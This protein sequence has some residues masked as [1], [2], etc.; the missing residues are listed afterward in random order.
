MKYLIP[1]ILLLTSLNVYAADSA[2]LVI[3]EDFNS[4]TLSYSELNNDTSV[5][6]LLRSEAKIDTAYGGGFVSKIN[7]TPSSKTKG[8]DWFY[9]V[10]GILA[11]EG[12][13]TYKVNP[14][15]H[16]WWDYHT[17]KTGELVSAVIGAFPD[18]FLNGY[19]NNV[20]PTAI[21]SSKPQHSSA[22]LLEKF[23]SNS[24]VQNI[25]QRDLNT[26]DT[27]RE[28]Y[29]IIIGAWSEISKNPF[30]IDLYKASKKVGF[31]VS[32]SDN[33]LTYNDKK[34]NSAST[35]MAL[36]SAFS[37]TPTWLITGTGDELVKR[38]VD[39]L[40]NEPN[41]IENIAAALITPETIYSLPGMHA[42]N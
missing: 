10:N 33:L 3:S 34:F 5:M 9:Y 1:I 40:I 2:K 29:K 26:I 8:K 32:F 21:Y 13:L 25:T 28:E 23:L 17:W 14:G 39:V 4:P 12:A 27:K 36:N 41:K 22:D 7:D 31:L 38:A 15:D 19:K 30:V 37:R 11:N 42:V 18:P 6:D 35:I 16:V 24:K 20:L